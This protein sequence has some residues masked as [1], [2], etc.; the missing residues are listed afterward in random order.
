MSA[1]GSGSM[2]VA[3]PFIA[4]DFHHQLLAGL[5]GAPIIPR[6]IWLE[7][8]CPEPRGI[9]DEW[10]NARLN[11]MRTK[12]AKQILLRWTAAIKEKAEKLLGNRERQVAGYIERGVV[13]PEDAYVIAVNGRR[14]RGSAFASI[15]GI[16][17]HPYAVEAVFA[18]GPFGIQID[19]QTLETT[20]SGHQHRPL[21]LRPSG[22][23]V[24]ADTFFDPRF[25]R[26]S[27]ILAADI[28]ETS[29]IGSLKPTAMIYNPN[30]TQ[31]VPPGLFPADWDYVASPRGDAEYLLEQRSGR[32]SRC[33]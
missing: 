16:S 28:D 32:L 12:P 31:P 27:A 22:A 24:P 11:E 20:G 14:L 23:P 13:G 2:R 25:R 7:T 1:H 17:Q 10:L 29:V 4:V 18:V 5:T 19:P 3:T 9:P 33:S 6:K 30:A 15:T 26:V 8:I 21:I